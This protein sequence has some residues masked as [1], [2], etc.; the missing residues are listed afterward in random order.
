DG[1]RMSEIYR[2]RRLLLCWRCS[3][4]HRSDD[5]NWRF[6][7]MGGVDQL[8]VSTRAPRPAE[9]A[10]GVEVPAHPP[11]P[12]VLRP[13]ECA[14]QAE[15]VLRRHAARRYV[16]RMVGEERVRARGYRFKAEGAA[17]V[18]NTLALAA[19]FRVQRTFLSHRQRGCAQQHQYRTP[20][21]TRL[22][23]NSPTSSWACS[24]WFSS[25]L[26]S[27]VCA[28]AVR[29]Q[30]L[31]PVRAYLWARLSSVGWPRQHALDELRRSPHVCTS[32]LRLRSRLHSRK[33]RC[34]T[35]G[36]DFFRPRANAESALAAAR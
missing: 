17:R 14:A 20:P 9:G 5:L 30:R 23:Q 22:L 31:S 2:S 19:Q 36:A 34:G 10:G 24:C 1:V 25:C 35:G 7:A 18:G 16:E 27:R 3:P 13:Y 12:G 11:I 32:P 29:Q 28:P 8:H 33:C 4:W 26:W 21:H 15:S 6:G